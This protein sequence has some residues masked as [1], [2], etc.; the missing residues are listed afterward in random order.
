MKMPSNFSGFILNSASSWLFKFLP[1]AYK[2][3]FVP[4]S[5]FGS[6]L[7]CASLISMRY[8][9]SIIF[10]YVCLT[11]CSHS[12]V[13]RSA[14]KI[15]EVDSGWANNSVNAVIF[16]KNSLVTFKDTQFIAYY[17]PDAD[18]ILGKRAL[19]TTS[20]QLQK[21]RYKGNASDAHNSIS[22]MV[23]GEGYLHVAWDH[24]NNPLH[25]A[26]S[27]APGSMEL[28]D[29]QPMTGLEEA[30]VSYPEFYQLP[31]G[32]L[33]FLYRNGGSGKGNLVINR[34]NHRT[35]IWQ[36]L[37]SNLIDGELQR[38]AYWQA[39]LDSKGTIHLSWVWRESPDV[40]SN[41]DL[42][43]ARSNDGGRTWEKSTGEIYDLP[44]TNRTA[45]IAAQIPQN[46]ELINQTSMVA[47]GDGNPYI[48]TYWR[49][50][51]DS[52]PQYQLVYN[53]GDQWQIRN[54]GFRK[55]PFSLSGMG[56][57]RIPISRPQIIAG[58]IRNKAAAVLLFRD[59]ERASLVSAAI[60]RNLRKPTWRVKNLTNFP[61][62]SWEPSYDTEL[63]K[64]RQELHLFIQ[65]VTQ[66]D[67]EGIAEIK[68]TMVK[69]LEWQ[70][71]F[72]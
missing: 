52:I 17:S 27:V 32:D 47:D 9:Y 30:A 26:K 22:I 10:V 13:S 59:E 3:D 50:P 67:G 55:T 70:K 57:K 6:G 39:C 49:E 64:N 46:S 62:G 54:P 11:G 63:W 38:N 7:N 68:P 40:A 15:I 16:R 44:I 41:H 35:K 14:L 18:L 53:S 12:S 5:Q 2:Y 1:L 66:V 29:Q 61:V 42:C 60:C 71:V 58:R 34:Y 21:T 36:Q 48:A 24:H 72:K 25:Y 23:D 43:Y 65:E 37:H 45:E 19:I 56:S 4:H 31:E 8:L 51:S 33:L 69:V 20:W 28:E